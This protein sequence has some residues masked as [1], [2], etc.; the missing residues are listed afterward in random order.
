VPSRLQVAPAKHLVLM[1]AAAGHFMVI[2]G[3]DLLLG[4]AATMQEGAVWLAFLKWP[5]TLGAKLRTA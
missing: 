1:I 4:C 3:N 5:D 2:A